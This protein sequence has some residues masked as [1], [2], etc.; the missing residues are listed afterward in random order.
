VP[1]ITQLTKY[2]RPINT[3]GGKGV[4]KRGVVKWHH[5]IAYSSRDEPAPRDDELPNVR[6]QGTMMVG[7][8]IKSRRKKDK[9]DPM[10][11]ID[12]ARMY[13]V[14]HNVKVYDFGEVHKDSMDRLVSQWLM[15]I[16]AGV[17]SNPILPQMPEADENDDSSSDG[18]NDNDDEDDEDDDDDQPTPAARPAQDYTVSRPTIGRTADTSGTGKGRQTQGR[19]YGL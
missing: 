7:V 8:R 4:S 13:T 14:E 2:S 16:E 18:E 3:Y 19:R 9:L 11:R 1:H 12:F 6:E 5:A 10:S 15:V 17:G